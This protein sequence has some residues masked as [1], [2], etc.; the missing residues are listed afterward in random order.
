[1][2]RGW[3][4]EER[5]VLI[6]NLGKTCLPRILDCFTEIA[7]WL[8]LTLYWE[9]DRVISS[10]ISLNNIYLNCLKL[11]EKLE[12]ALEGTPNG[13]AL[14]AWDGT[15]A[16]F[17]LQM[18]AK[19]VFRPALLPAILWCWQSLYN[20]IH[21]ESRCRL[22]PTLMPS[23]TNGSVAPVVAT[24]GSL[25]AYLLRGHSQFHLEFQLFLTYVLI[26]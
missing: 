7:A 5:M 17:P 16:F 15:H 18:P 24:E 6:S 10:L 25:V 1:M 20:E 21:K 19:T 11:Q 14:D 9:M 8:W 13:S 26:S 12:S 22:S 3:V 2:A 4:G 23:V